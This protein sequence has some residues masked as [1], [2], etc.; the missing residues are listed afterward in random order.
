[1]DIISGYV[2]VKE[3]AGVIKIIKGLEMSRSLV[4]LPEIYQQKVTDLQLLFLAFSG[5]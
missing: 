3:V 5:L 2:I 4:R 1:M